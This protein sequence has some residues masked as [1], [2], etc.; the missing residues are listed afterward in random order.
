MN[1]NAYEEKNINLRQ[2]VFVFT[3]A[4]PLKKT[5]IKRRQALSTSEK[6]F[7]SLKREVIALVCSKSILGALKYTNVLRAKK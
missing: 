5:Q 1:S 4:R 6:N 2:I 3:Y 7:Y